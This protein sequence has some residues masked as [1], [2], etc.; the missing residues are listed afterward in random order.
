MI[1][2]HV[3]NKTFVLQFADPLDRTF[4]P[5]DDENNNSS[6]LQQVEKMP[7]QPAAHRV[8]TTVSKAQHQSSSKPNTKSRWTPTEKN[9]AKTYFSDYLT[10]KTN[11][12]PVS[13]LSNMLESHSYTFI[14]R[15]IGTIRTWLHSQRKKYLKQATA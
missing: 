3:F 8:Q 7:S 15:N 2:N 13:S 10:G 4:V 5:N 6:T 9:V 11:T 1:S 12:V 14:G